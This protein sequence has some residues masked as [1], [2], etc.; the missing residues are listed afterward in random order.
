MDEVND[1]LT[2]LEKK[3]LALEEKVNEE[4]VESPVESLIDE[5]LKY[6]STEMQDWVEKKVLKLN[7]R[8]LKLTEEVEKVKGLLL[9]K[10]GY[11]S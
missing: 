3:L 9:K 1:R 8:I 11:E 7:G 10:G 2:S 6:K 5:R 4:D